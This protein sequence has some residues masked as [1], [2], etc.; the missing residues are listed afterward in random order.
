MKKLL[1]LITIA[2]LSWQNS[3]AQC[4]ADRH[5]TNW[6]DGWISCNTST[7]PIASKG[8][9]HWIMY[10][11]GQAYQIYNL[12]LWNAN[13]PDHLDYGIMNYSIDYSI[14]GSN[15]VSSG[16]FSLN[17]ASGLSVYEGEQGPNLGG[18]SARYVLITPISNYGGSCYGLSE[19]KFSLEEVVLDVI[20]SELGFDINVYPNP[21][22]D[23]INLQVNTQFPEESIKYA[24]YDV[25]GRKI[26][27]KTI[28][29]P[30][31]VNSITISGK[32]LVTGIYFVKISHN[33]TEKSFKIIKK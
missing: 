16:S 19:V 27:S 28:E 15:W 1:F 9:T 11:F 6:Y 10:D 4:Y 7:N 21:F 12:T 33:N 29:N 25:L 2:L 18:V 14:D 20:D 13:D 31:T 32:Q 8:N 17:Q 24:I 22:D 30:S 3:D 23:I 5:S 26:I